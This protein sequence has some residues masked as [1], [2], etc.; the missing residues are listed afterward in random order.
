MDKS[1]KI[2]V[3][4]N[5]YI[6]Y[7]FPQQYERFSVN[8]IYVISNIYLCYAILVLVIKTLCRS[9]LHIYNLW[10]QCGESFSNN[11]FLNT[12]KVRLVKAV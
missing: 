12:V 7:L 10:Y 8:F 11:I 9:V 2:G 6:H 5:Q 4:I 1:S 3:D